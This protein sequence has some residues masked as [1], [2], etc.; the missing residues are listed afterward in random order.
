MCKILHIGTV[1]SCFSLASFLIWLI[2]S[3]LA[4]ALARCLTTLSAFYGSSKFRQRIFSKAITPNYP[5][6]L[7][8][9]SHLNL[10]VLDLPGNLPEGQLLL[11]SRLLGAACTPPLPLLKSGKTTASKAIASSKLLTRAKALQKNRESR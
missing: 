9:R 4:I 10:K 3:P 2:Y 1:F 6:S 5:I 11:R 7:P 8:T